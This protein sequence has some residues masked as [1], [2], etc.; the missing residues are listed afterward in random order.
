MQPYASQMITSLESL[1]NDGGPVSIGWAATGDAIRRLDR[2]RQAPEIARSC[3]DLILRSYPQG[4]AQ[5][6]A[7]VHSALK[8][9]SCKTLM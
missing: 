8:G 5:D 4:G 2:I 6:L 7:N 3:R 1:L 9:R